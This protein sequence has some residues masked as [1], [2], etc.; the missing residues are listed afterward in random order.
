MYWCG[1]SSSSSATGSQIVECDNEEHCSMDYTYTPATDLTSDSDEELAPPA[2][3]KV[4]KV[5]KSIVCRY[6]TKHSWLV[7]D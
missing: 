6:N 5:A 7:S 2:T 4:A 1:G 3:K